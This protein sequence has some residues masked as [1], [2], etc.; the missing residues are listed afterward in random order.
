MA[1][2]QRSYARGRLDVPKGGKSRKVEL[3]TRLRAL[4]RGLYDARYRR[5]A[6]ISPDAQARLEA[7]Q[8]AKAS[9]E[10]IFPGTDGGFLDEHNLRHRVWEP[11]L[12]AAKL[13]HRRLHVLRHSFATLHL[14][15]GTDPVWV[16]AQLGHHSIGFTLSTYAH[17]PLGDRIDS[18][19]KCN[20]RQFG[21]R[22][23][24]RG[25]WT[26]PGFSDTSTRTGR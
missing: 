26:S 16:S 12:V 5:L 15:G 11:L 1:L 18:A 20:Q 13:R 19:T 10:L 6:A 2:V 25:P 23:C 7:E 22:E 14:H 3:S 17:P 4:L 24:G 8:A 21:R 9:D